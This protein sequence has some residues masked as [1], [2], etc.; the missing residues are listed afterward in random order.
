MLLCNRDRIS[1]DECHIEKLQEVRRVYLEMMN[2]LDEPSRCMSID[3]LY[4]S[5]EVKKRGYI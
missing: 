5:V 2:D 3:L 1:Q 4:A